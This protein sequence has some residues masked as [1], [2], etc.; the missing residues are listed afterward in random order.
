[1]VFSTE[2]P[3][4]TTTQLPQTGERATSWAQWLGAVCLLVLGGGGLRWWRRH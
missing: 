1:M 3:T 4:S 2:T